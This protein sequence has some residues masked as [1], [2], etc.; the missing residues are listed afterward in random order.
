MTELLGRVWRGLTTWPERR[1]WVEA[2]IGALIL[3]AVTI[4]VGFPSGFLVFQPVPPLHALWI[5]PFVFVAPGLIEETV[6]RGYLPTWNETR[7]PWVWIGVSLAVF[8]AYHW[9]LTLFLDGAAEIF[10]RW[11]FLFG[12]AMIGLVCAI[13]RMRS[14]SIWPGV[15][16]HGLAVAVWITLLGGRAVRDIT[17]G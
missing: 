12:A 17:W 15:A 4:A 5:A 11:E 16:V 8:L 2:S 3:S 14:G 1:H 9:V 13:L 6:W 10:L 7:A